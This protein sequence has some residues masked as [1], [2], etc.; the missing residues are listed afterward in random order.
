[1]KM[2]VIAIPKE[3]STPIEQCEGLKVT[4]DYASTRLTNNC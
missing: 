3:R 4:K 1:M 2:M